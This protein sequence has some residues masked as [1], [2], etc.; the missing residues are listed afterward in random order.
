MT[1]SGCRPAGC[2]PVVCPTSLALGQLRSPFCQRTCGFL[3]STVLLPY[4]HSLLPAS[5]TCTR[6]SFSHTLAHLPGF[7]WHLSLN[8][9]FY[10]Q[11]SQTSRHLLHSF[12]KEIKLKLYAFCSFKALCF[13][14]REFPLTPQQASVLSDTRADQRRQRFHGN[15]QHP[16][17]HEKRLAKQVMPEMAVL[18]LEASTARE[19]VAREATGGRGRAG[20]RGKRPKA[21]FSNTRDVSVGRAQAPG[22]TSFTPIP[23]FHPCGSPSF[24]RRPHF[25]LSQGLFS[26]LSTLLIGLFLTAFSPSL[27]F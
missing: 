23:S 7:L 1:D 16:A 11:G 5:V 14:W 25:H 12:R 19:A 10:I 18:G 20:V 4:V 27:A 24:T 2:P 22:A 26:G 21:A 17:S 13:V 15:Q 9:S 3:S 8:R 6:R